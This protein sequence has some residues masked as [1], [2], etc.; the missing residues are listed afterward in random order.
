MVDDCAATALIVD[1]QHLDDGRVLMERC[2][3]LR[4][5]IYLGGG[6][7][8]DGMLSWDELTSG[9][10]GA[11]PELESG[12]LAAIVYTGGTSGRA[13]GVMLSHGNLLANAK[14]YTI[15]IKHLRS[16]RYLHTLPMFHVADTSRRTR[17]RGSAAAVILPGF[18]PVGG[19]PRWSSGSGSRCCS[20]CR[21]RSRCC[22]SIRRATTVICRACACC[23]TRRRRC[24]PNCSV[25][26][27]RLRCEFSQMYGMTEAAPL[28]THC[29]AEDHRRG[30]AGEE[31]YARRLASAG[32]AIVGTQV[33]VHDSRTGERVPDGTPGEIWVRGPNVM[34]GYL[35]LPDATAAALTP[36]GGIAPATWRSPTRTG[37]CTSSTAPQGHDRQR[38]RE[39]LLDRGRARAVRVPGVCEAAVF[40]VPDPKWGERVHA[41]VVIE[42]GHDAASDELI[43][44]VRGLIAGYKAPR[45]VDI[46]TDPLPKSAAGKILKRE[47]R[48]PY[49]VLEARQV[50]DRTSRTLARERERHM[51]N[52]AEILSTQPSDFGS[53]PALIHGDETART[54][55]SMTRAHGWRMCC[56]HGGAGR[57]TR[58]RDAAQRPRV[59]VCVLRRSARRVHCRAD[60]RDVQAARGCVLP[61]RSDATVALVWHTLADEARPA[62]STPVRRWSSS[63]PAASAHRVMSRPAGSSRGPAT[64]WG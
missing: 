24:P 40:G 55:S 61:E 8:P 9:E 12:T 28:V 29:T 17:L 32:A 4:T 10:P 21:Q 47:L 16:D 60:E 59:S 30:A 19:A 52:V 13:K 62:R 56:G 2:T 18:E 33:E 44:H 57:A 58:R 39:R 15:A 54:V 50:S 42:E 34:H 48:D 63:E 64:R 31:P 38:R 23:S 22:S 20:W 46:R 49:W 37:T 1:Q 27:D 53:R 14:Q 3:S 5:L 25:G 7:P 45:S 6:S 26:M 41:V 36:E 35:K 11:F 43:A 51:S